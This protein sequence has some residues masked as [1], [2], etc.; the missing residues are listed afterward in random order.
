MS[1]MLSQ[2][3]NPDGSVSQV[4]V[5]QR[6]WQGLNSARDDLTKAIAMLQ[7]PGLP[8]DVQNHLQ[9]IFPYG[10]TQEVKQ[11]LIGNF[12]LSLN[13][14]NDLLAGKIPVQ[15]FNQAD[16]SPGKADRPTAE[17]GPTGLRVNVARFCDPGQQPLSDLQLTR[18]FIH[19]ASHRGAATVDNWYL[20]NNGY[21]GY[22]FIGGN[23][24]RFDPN[25]YQSAY[26]ANAD[27]NA[28]AAMMLNNQFPLY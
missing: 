11:G 7:Q 17:M 25:S 28:V 18:T 3:R 13:T 23:T 20:D 2:V 27:T 1:S 16:P 21:A 10:V 9:R 5:S 8:S 24:G 4:P 14:V 22:G 15:Y 19:E 6:V 26:L 12:Q